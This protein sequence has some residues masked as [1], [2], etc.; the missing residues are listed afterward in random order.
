M[1]NILITGANG[2]I[3]QH[4]TRKLVDDGHSVRT[5]HRDDSELYFFRPGEVDFRRADI[6]ERDSISELMGGI[7]I[8]YH[9]AAIARNDLSKSWDDYYAVNVQGT[10]NLLE[11]AKAAGVRRFVFISTVEAAGFGDGANPRREDDPPNPANNYGRSKLLAEQQVLSGKWPME[12]T[13]LRLPMVYG[14]G[15]F[16][17]VPKLFGMV[18]RGFYPMIGGG[19]TKME[20]CFVDNAVNGIILAGEKAEAAGEL[21]YISD[22]RPYTIKEVVSN[23][24]ASMDKK[25]TFIHIP[26]FIANLCGLCWEIAARVLPFPPIVSKYSRKPFFSRETVYWTTRDV[27]IVSIEKIKNKLGYSPLVNINDGTRRTAEWLN[28]KLFRAGAKL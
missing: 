22:E 27:N 23:I 14:P 28:E 9:L 16:L 24:A 4:L 6:S 10:I 5:V 25:V 8:V 3:G 12:C 2:F 19:K 7:D 18:R 11:E 13:V 21:F 20:F 26:I 15:T 17:I 1:P